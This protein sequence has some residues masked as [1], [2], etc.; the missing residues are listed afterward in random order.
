M[1]RKANR[2]K[3]MTKGYQRLNPSR[4]TSPPDLNMKTKITKCGDGPPSVIHGCEHDVNRRT[5]RAIRSKPA[6]LNSVTRG[7]ALGCRKP[8]APRPNRCKEMHVSPHLGIGAED[9]L[10]PRTRGKK[11]MV[12]NL[13]RQSEMIVKW[14]SKRVG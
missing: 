13:K 3:N 4:V 10:N 6:D 12:E 5:R 2:N 8:D 7:G 9:R 14:R 1:K 11:E